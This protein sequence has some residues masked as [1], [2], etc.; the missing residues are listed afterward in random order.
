MRTLL[1]YFSIS[2][3]IQLVNLQNSL[4]LIMNGDFLNT[5]CQSITCYYRILNYT[6]QLHGWMP[7]P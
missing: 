1:F 6:G 4:N 5:T 7:N 3:V 2:I